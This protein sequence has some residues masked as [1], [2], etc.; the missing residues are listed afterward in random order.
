[1]GRYCSPVLEVL[2]N[3][4]TENVLWYRMGLGQA[5]SGPSSR[6]CQALVLACG[7]LAYAGL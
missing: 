5:E 7:R 4:P 6:A 2:W 1:M 3:F